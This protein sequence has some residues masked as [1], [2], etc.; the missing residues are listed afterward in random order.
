VPDSFE[1]HLALMY[2]LLTLAYQADLTRVFTFMSDRE[3]SQRTY[4]QINVNEQHHTVSHHGNDPANI[5]KVIK[6]NTY[7]VELFAR[8]LAK[9]RSTPDGDGSLLDHSLI[10]YGGGMGNPNQH[11]SDPLPLLAVGGGVGKGNRHIQ[12]PQRTPVGNLWLSV[13]HRYG[14]VIDSIGES[15]GTVDL[16]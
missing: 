16:F 3:L 7:H 11:A 5:A 8:F 4:P 15:T 10:V 14:S 9:L 2:D 13:A 6:I 1:E 12:L